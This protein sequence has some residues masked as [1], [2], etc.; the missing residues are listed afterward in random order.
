MLRC[1]QTWAST[2]YT[3]RGRVTIQLSFDC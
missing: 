2:P 3:K 1:R